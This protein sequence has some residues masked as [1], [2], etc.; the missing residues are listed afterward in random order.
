M[1]F[2][3]LFSLFFD[4]VVCVEASGASRSADDHVR[5]LRPRPLAHLSVPPP[6]LIPGSAPWCDAIR[7]LAAGVFVI[8]LDRTD[9][10][11]FHL[12]VRV[13]PWRCGRVLAGATAKYRP[14]HS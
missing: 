2:S 6:H 12:S 10:D 11:T 8:A 7:Q 5:A 14:K 4:V 13:N 1:P 3:S 9:L